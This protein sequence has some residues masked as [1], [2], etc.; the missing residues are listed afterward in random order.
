MRDLR[1]SFGS[2]EVLHSVDFHVLPG[3]MYVEGRLRRFLHPSQAVRAGIATIHQELSLVPTVTISDNLFL[4]QERA[5]PLG[6][7]L[8]QGRASLDGHRAR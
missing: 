5:G 7:S 4:G 8:H 3:K 2:T 6:P 1:E